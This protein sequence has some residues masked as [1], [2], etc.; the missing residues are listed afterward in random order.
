MSTASGAP[1]VRTEGLT[2]RYGAFQALRDVTVSLPA[3]GISGLIGPNGAGKT[4]LLNAISGFT[5]IAEGSVHIGHRNITALGT[6]RRA[7]AGVVRGFQTVRLMERESV[8]TNVL[9]GTER[10][11][12]PNALAQFLALPSQWRARNRD[13]A[14]A[15]EV[16]D[17]LGLARQ[18][19]RRVD[20]LPFASRRLVEVARV[21]V[22]SPSVILLDEPAAGLDQ[23][24]RQELA[25]VLTRVHENHPSTMV[26]VEHDVDLVKS[27]C[28]YVIA[29]D[30]GAF[31]RDG[32]PA[33]VFG[34][35]QVQLAYFGRAASAD[36]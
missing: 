25:A 18:A 35:R 32:T 9:V 30:S 24:G 29:L 27:L 28:S 36:A 1:H 13:M 5:P 23:E 21:L 26:V 11:P 15:T 10:L 20:E 6:R 7:L 17:L 16:L 4:T 19:H 2:V 33:E 34:D 8:L 31:L 3:G 22:S 14:A 12:Q